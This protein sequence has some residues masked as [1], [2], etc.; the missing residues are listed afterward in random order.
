VDLAL[1]DFKIQAKEQNIKY[2]IGY[3][4]RCI[5]N[6]IF[7]GELRIESDLLYRDLI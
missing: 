6:A 4:S 2:P 7:Q 3:L 5:Y 1:R